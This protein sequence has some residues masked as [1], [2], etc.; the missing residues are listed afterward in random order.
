[1]LFGKDEPKSARKVFHYMNKVPEQVKQIDGKQQEENCM[2]TRDRKTTRTNQRMNVRY[3][4]DDKNNSD[5]VFP[6]I[7]PERDRTFPSCPTGEDVCV[8]PVQNLYNI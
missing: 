2:K 6:E 3:L 4:V 7:K 8:T 1:M 5:T